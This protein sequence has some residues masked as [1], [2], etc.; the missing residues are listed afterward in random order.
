MRLHKLIR[1]RFALALIIQQ[2]D[3][4]LLFQQTKLQCIQSQRKASSRKNQQE[5]VAMDIISRREDSAAK[6]KWRKRQEAIN[7]QDGKNQWLRFRRAICL[8]SREQDLYYSGKQYDLQRM[9]ARIWKEDKLAISSAE[10]I[11][12]L[13]NGHISNR[14][15]IFEKR[16]LK[17]CPAVQS[18]RDA[19]RSFSWCYYNTVGN[20]H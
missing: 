5:D 1:Q 6:F 3:F 8:N 2:E 13:S 16:P 4:A 15:Y 12:N 14:G 18:E 17:K 7:A 19:M 10:Q 20:I 11:W 9:F